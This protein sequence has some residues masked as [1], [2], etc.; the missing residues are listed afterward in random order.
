MTALPTPD[1]A[2]ITERLVTVEK[3]VAELK[4][5]VEHPAV[6]PWYL[7]HAGKFAGDPE[8]QEIVRL[9]KEIREADRP[10]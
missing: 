1:L 7:K 6:Q 4:R 10:V 8:F 9:G 5:R 2:T 3:E